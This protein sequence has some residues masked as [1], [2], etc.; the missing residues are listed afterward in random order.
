[1][2]KPQLQWKNANAHIA[3]DRASC[4]FIVSIALYYTANCGQ[5]DVERNPL[6]VSL[7]ALWR[8]PKKRFYANFSILRI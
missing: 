4:L 7:T 3:I 1:M 6:G 8:L 2:G 5:T